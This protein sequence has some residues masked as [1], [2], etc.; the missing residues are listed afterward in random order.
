M[1]KKLRTVSIN[2]K[3]TGSYKKSLI[4]AYYLFFNPRP[5]G[6]SSKETLKFCFTPTTISL[7]LHIKIYQ[8]SILLKRYPM[9]L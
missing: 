1:C 4:Y 9:T 3:F 5:L 2:S 6:E 8:N 7:K